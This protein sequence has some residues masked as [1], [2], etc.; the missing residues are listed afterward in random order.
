MPF[1]RGSSQPRDWTQISLIAGGFLIIW[2]TRVAPPKK[3]VH[4]LILKYVIAKKCYH[5]SLQQ[6]V[7]VLRV[8]GLKYRENYQNVTETESEQMLLEKWRR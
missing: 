7:I 1:S 4:I 3:I 2:V 8:E 5:G 6:A